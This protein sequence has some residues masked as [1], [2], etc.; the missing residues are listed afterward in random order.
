M[1]GFGG[2]REGSPVFDSYRR[3]LGGKAPYLRDSWDLTAVN[4]AFEG[5]GEYYAL[6]KEMK[7]TVED[8]AQPPPSRANTQSAIICCKRRPTT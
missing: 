7:I 2:E 6:S 8:D 5:C 1:T 4:Y 3:Y